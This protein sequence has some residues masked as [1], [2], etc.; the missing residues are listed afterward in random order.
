MLK[1]IDIRSV[2]SPRKGQ[3]I[4]E[5]E[6]FPVLNTDSSINKRPLNNENLDTNLGSLTIFAP[7]SHSNILKA[8][9]TNGV[10]EKKKANFVGGSG[11]RSFP[12]TIPEVAMEVRAEIPRTGMSTGDEEM[13][14]RVFNALLD[15]IVDASQIISKKLPFSL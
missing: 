11:K 15:R 9:Q 10:G 5:S 2:E 8:T 3:Q 13:R 12:R 1:F 7:C 4:S 6:F 14:K